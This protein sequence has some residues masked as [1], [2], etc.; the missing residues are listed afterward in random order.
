MTTVSDSFAALLHNCERINAVLNLH[1]LLRS[2]LG[3]VASRGADVASMFFYDLDMKAAHTFFGEDGWEAK[4]LG[5]GSVY[6]VKTLEQ[7]SVDVL[8][9]L[10][11][12][13]AATA[14]Q[15]DPL[16]FD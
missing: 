12:G 2:C 5:N 4:M 14:K 11:D 6:S 1:P 8:V 10:R 9:L 13:E 7:W 16:P 15:C 3:H